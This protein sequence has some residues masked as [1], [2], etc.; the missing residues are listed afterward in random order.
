MHISDKSTWI[1]QKALSLGFD[2]C[3]IAEATSLDEDA[4]RLEKW[5]HQ[6]K[7][8][9][10]QY[11]ENYFDLRIDPRKLFPGAKSVITVLKNYYS[12]EKIQIQMLRKSP[13]MPMGKIITKLFANN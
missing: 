6:G 2:H 3:G 4:F 7:H 8:G 1:K 11:M 12:S 10:M 13:N 5:L 9:S